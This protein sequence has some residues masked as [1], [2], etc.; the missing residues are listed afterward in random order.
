ML[1]GCLQCVLGFS[2]RTGKGRGDE[3]CA[4]DPMAEV[5]RPLLSRCTRAWCPL[6][7]SRLLAFEEP[8]TVHPKICCNLRKALTLH[9]ALSLA[10]RLTLAKQYVKKYN[11]AALQHINAMPQELRIMKEE[12]ENFEGLMR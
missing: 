3:P 6:L 4:V 1:K 2:I 11:Q 7:I 10:G 5:A 8:S 9:S 12:D